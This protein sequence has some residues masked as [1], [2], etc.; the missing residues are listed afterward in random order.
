M[1]EILGLDFEAA[2]EAQRAELRDKE[3]AHFKGK[4]VWTNDCVNFS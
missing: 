3:D 2:K 1:G 4:R